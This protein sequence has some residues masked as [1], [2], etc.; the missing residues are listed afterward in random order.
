[1]PKPTQQN[2][3]LP[4][5][6]KRGFLKQLLGLIAT[7]TVIPTEQEQA[8]IN[9]QAARR[10]GIEGNRFAMLIDLRKCIGCQACTVSCSVENLPPIGQ[11]RT[12][13]LQYEVHE[14][15]GG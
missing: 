13:V 8:P 3:N 9:E 4:E 7:A 15:D 10:P 2:T 11:F 1:M 6:G 5:K 14:Y 12:T